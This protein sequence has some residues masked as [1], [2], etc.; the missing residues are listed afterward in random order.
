M[1][2]SFFFFHFIIED[3][4]GNFIESASNRFW[5]AVIIV[6]FFRQNRCHKTIEV[7]RQNR[8]YE[9]YTFFFNVKIKLRRKKEKNLRG[10]C[11]WSR[12]YFHPTGNL[13]IYVGNIISRR[14]RAPVVTVAA[15]A[16]AAHRS[17]TCRQKFTTGSWESNRKQKYHLVNNWDIF[18]GKMNSSRIGLDCFIAHR[19]REWEKTKTK[20]TCRS[21]IS[22]T[23]LP[24]SSS[25]FLFFIKWHGNILL[26]ST[27]PNRWCNAF[28]RARDM[29][30][31][32]HS[33][34]YGAPSN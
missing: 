23:A 8:H 7:W 24:S 26:H 22:P 32:W 29:R 31:K 25:S 30:A 13:F 12:R 4:C 21:I 5:W 2:I 6:V 20:K 9:T 14:S 19:P 28:F 3:Y 16:A 1:G 10:K 11:C 27:P 15:A 18:K 17:L 33:T 34:K